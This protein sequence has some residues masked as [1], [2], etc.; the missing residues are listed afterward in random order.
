MTAVHLSPAEMQ[1]IN[2]RTR[3]GFGGGKVVNRTGKQAVAMPHHI[4]TKFNANKYY[5]K[6]HDRL[7]EHDQENRE[8]VNRLAGNPVAVKKTRP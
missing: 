1:E 7:K 3:H 6:H 4:T 5:G 2:N 8:H